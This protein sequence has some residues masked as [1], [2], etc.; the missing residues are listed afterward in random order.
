MT[1]LLGSLLGWICYL[2][3]IIILIR[4][5]FSWVA[6]TDYNNRLYGFSHRYSEPVLGPIRRLL[7]PTAGIDFSPMLALLGLGILAQI[8]FQL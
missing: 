7:P 2:Y 6:P 8:F 1:L 4:V 5:I 3:A